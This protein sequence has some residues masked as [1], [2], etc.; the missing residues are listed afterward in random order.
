MVA[1]AIALVLY[2]DAV[3]SSVN[4]LTRRTGGLSF[5]YS[6]LSLPLP[7]AG[8]RL[9]TL[10]E[11]C[12]VWLIVA[13]VGGGMWL[14]NYFAVELSFL[15]RSFMNSFTTKNEAMFLQVLTSFL[16]LLGIMILLGPCYSW[17]KGS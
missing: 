8:R 4:W 12:K 13:L 6:P 1:V 16:P 14:V 3:N 10:P 5:A 2:C 7:F 15:N 11:L 17:V 9:L